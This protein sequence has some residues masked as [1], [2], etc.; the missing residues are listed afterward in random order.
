MDLYKI[1]TN[2][3]FHKLKWEKIKNIPNWYEVKNKKKFVADLF[4]GKSGYWFIV[5]PKEIIRC[6]SIHIIEMIAIAKTFNKRT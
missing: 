2:L 1:I 3:L 6:K 5:M 4:L